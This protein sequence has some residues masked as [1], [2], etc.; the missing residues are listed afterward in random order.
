MIRS[1]QTYKNN[2]NLL[3]IDFGYG[4]PQFIDNSYQFDEPSFAL[5]K[6]SDRLPINNNVWILPPAIMKDEVFTYL[7]EKYV[8]NTFLRYIISNYGRLYDTLCNKFVPFR[9]NNYKEE[10]PTSP[11]KGYCQAHV[12]YYKS[13]YEIGNKDIYIHRAVL[14]SFNYIE[15]CEKLDVNHKDGIH[16][17]NTLKNLEW[18]TPLE[19]INHSF[20]TGLSLGISERKYNTT[21]R[22]EINESDAEKIC[23]LYITGHSLREISDMLNIYQTIVFNVLSG[24]TM[25]NISSKYST[26]ISNVR[27]PDE[28]IHKLCTLISKGI[29]ISDISAISG[30]SKYE[31]L[32]IRDRKIY[33][34]ISIN[35]DF[36][37]AQDIDSFR[38]T[39]PPAIVHEICRRLQIGEPSSK[40]AADLNVGLKTITNIKSGKIYKEIAVYYNFARIN[41]ETLDEKTIRNICKDIEFGIGNADIGRK[42]NINPVTVGHIR[43]GETYN[44]ISKDYKLDTPVTL[45]R[46]LD[47][48]TVHEIC[49]RLQA[50]E[51]PTAIANDMNINVRAINSIHQGLSYKDISKDYTFSVKDHW[52]SEDKVRAVCE[53]LQRGDRLI[54]I[55]N[56]TGVSKRSIYRIRDR[57]IYH[58]ITKDYNY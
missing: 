21:K 24:N 1:N 55:I 17:N 3:F 25:Q 7:S 51:T 43:R 18:L 14:M 39:L 46:E 53:A 57:E 52:L 44:Y 54:D 31:L 23:N 5:C 2:S 35:Y 8:P 48:K 49:Y 34:E 38:R 30:I 33:K 20:S 16:L 42:Y 13:P 58:D 15:G 32:D 29:P 22:L 50:G 40:I 9:L 28:S 37:K 19:N 6:I 12:A 27:I 11:N 56:N 41:E 4:Y 10:D 36:S 26:C 45:S 47:D